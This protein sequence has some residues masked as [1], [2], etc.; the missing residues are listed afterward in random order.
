MDSIRDYLS[1]KQFKGSE[2]M[3]SAMMFLLSV[4]LIGG[5]VIIIN[6]EDIF[7]KI[8]EGYQGSLGGSSSIPTEERMIFSGTA[9]ATSVCETG[10][11]KYS[12]TS[13]GVV[14]YFCAKC[15]DG[16][17][18]QYSDGTPVSPGPLDS[19]KITLGDS[20]QGL[21]C[22][23]PA[24]TRGA[25]AAVAAAVSAASGAS[26][27]SGAPVSDQISDNSDSAPRRP[28]DTNSRVSNSWTADLPDDLSLA[29]LQR[30]ISNLRKKSDFNIAI[31]AIMI[32]IGSII[33]IYQI[34]KLFFS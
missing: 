30:N 15:P 20:S 29:A 11:Q 18:L 24:G 21:R 4:F 27:A 17:N 22:K 6:D 8:Y 12:F 9:T 25:L 2:V 28:S 33:S 10:Y 34:Y 14:S 26:G 23:L 1:E 32:I 7:K 31:A 19:S 3:Q 13:E 5:G 16:R